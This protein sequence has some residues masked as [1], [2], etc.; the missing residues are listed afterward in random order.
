MIMR[1]LEKHL[2]ELKR[3]DEIAIKKADRRMH[4]EGGYNYEFSCRVSINQAKLMGKSESI[5]AILKAYIDNPLG[6]YLFGIKFK[7]EEVIEALKDTGFTAALMCSNLFY[8]AVAI[9][10]RSPGQIK[11]RVYIA[12]LNYTRYQKQ[13]RTSLKKLYGRKKSKGKNRI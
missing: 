10:S 11:L 12:I 8:R 7:E 9:N 2:F 3:K 5:C 13:Q 6:E 1:K 4:T